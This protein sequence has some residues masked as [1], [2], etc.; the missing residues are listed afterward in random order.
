MV[1]MDG[2]K[3]KVHY[4]DDTEDEVVTKDR[5]QYPL[6]GDL[7]AAK[8]AYAVAAATPEPM[9][10]AGEWEQVGAAGA[11]KAAVAGSV[12]KDRLYSMEG[13]GALHGTDLGSGDGKQ[14]GKAELAAA[15]FLFA[16]GE[17]LYAID[18]DGSLFKVD[19]KDGVHHRLGDEGAW[20]GTLAG[21]VLKG[22][23]YTT[24]ENGGLYVTNLESGEWKQIGK[25]EFGDTKFMFAAGDRLYT[26]EKD[27]SLYKVDPTDGSW[28]QLGERGAWKDT[29][30][31]VILKGK[32]YTTE[33]NGC[34]YET[35]LSNGAWVQLGK[36]EF[37]DTTFLFAAGEDAYTIEKSGSL[38]RVHVK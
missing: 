12:L 21:A 34:F 2:D 32:L 18:R 31:G 11:W 5:I 25:A 36:A 28:G 24:E 7:E 19:P 26:I 23:L 9:D 38:Y 20:K 37:G 10:H 22:Q 33:T 13:N 6:V 16:A 15:K 29:L 1:S 30:A 8:A 14:I 35:D 27:G 3:Y 4:I 17:F